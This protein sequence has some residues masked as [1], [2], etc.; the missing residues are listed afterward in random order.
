[1]RDRQADDGQLPGGISLAQF[2]RARRNLVR[3]AD[4]GLP[5]GGRRRVAGL[6]R[7]EVAVLAGISTDYYRRLEQGQEDNPSDQVLDAIGKAL[8]LDDDAV[9]YMRNLLRHNFQGGQVDPLQ[10]PHSKIG[11]L[12]DTWPLTI[13]LV[14]DP[15]MTVVR[16]N[17]LAEALSPHYGVGANTVRAIFLEPEMRR[18]YRDWERVTA[19][20]VSFIRAML[21][22]RPDPAL[23]GLVDELTERSRWFQQL[24]ARHDVTHDSVRRMLIDHPQVGPLDL[25]YQQMLLP[26]TGHWLVVY[27]AEPGSASDAGLR[28]LA[29]G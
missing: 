27:W 29:S 23:I 8:Q 13:A 5:A 12:L 4:V 9:T 19:W 16:A 17:K 10:R 18:F 20:S 7:E 24:W 1:M 6:R 26:G 28:H 14:V 21:G 15:G 3:P 11:V 25:N 2:L 22:Q